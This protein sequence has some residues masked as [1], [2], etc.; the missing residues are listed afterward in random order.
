[1]FQ[2]KRKFLSCLFKNMIATQFA[3][4][5]PNDPFG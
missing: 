5:I 3:V 2:Q 1:M 4:P